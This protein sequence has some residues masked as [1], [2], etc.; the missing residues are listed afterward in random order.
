MRHISEPTKELMRQLEKELMGQP[1]TGEGF[2]RAGPVTARREDERS[3]NVI[4]ISEWKRRHRVTTREAS[5][6]RR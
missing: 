3:G 2:R 4:W 5:P 6:R 1:Y